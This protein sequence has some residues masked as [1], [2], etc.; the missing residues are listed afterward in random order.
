M[1]TLEKYRELFGENR[2]PFTLVDY[3]DYYSGLIKEEGAQVEVIFANDPR[4][5]LNYTKDVLTCDIHTRARTKRLLKAAVP[6]RSA[7]WTTF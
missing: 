2:H 7:G 1:L 3:V 5:I 4:V 6:G